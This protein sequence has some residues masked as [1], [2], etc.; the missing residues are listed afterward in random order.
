VSREIRVAVAML[1]TMVVTAL[2]VFAD[3]PYKTMLD[4]PMVFTGTE[5]LAVV[6]ADGGEIRIGLFAPDGDDHPVGRDL[7]RGVAIAVEHANAAGG[8]DGTPLRVIR[9]WADDP[10]G[11]GSGELIRLVFEDR[12]LAVIGGPD[13]ASTHVA[14]QVATKA[15]LPLIAPISSDP[16]LTHTRVPWIFRLPP[17]D[18]T[19]AELLVV[20]G[21]LPRGVRR[22]AL[23][24]SDD[25]D[26]RTTAR[27]L[28]DAMARAGRPPAFVLATDPRLE[29]PVALASR[30]A[31][32]APDG[33]VLSLPGPSVRSALAALDGEGL[34]CPVF[35]PWIADLDLEAYPPHYGGPI[36]EAR[37]FADAQSCGPQLKFERAAIQRFGE[38]PSPAMVYGFDA[39]NLLID[40]LR[41]GGVG[42]VELRRRLAELSGTVG[43]SGTIHWDNGGGNTTRPVIRDLDRD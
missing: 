19:Q 33:V 41:A 2:P 38:R 43:A 17:D 39:A 29:D 35:L 42:R 21:M 4:E 1:G 20:E 10:W 14:Q 22:A 28:A 18:R 3:E 9:R 8:I 31:E 24:I 36:V 11:A 30:L 37:P 25:H 12:V 13:G 34:R 26:S 15:F 16:S 40:A 5:S 6:A 7:A 27:E 23:V 32:L